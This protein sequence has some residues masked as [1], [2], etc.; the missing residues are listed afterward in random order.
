VHA[1]DDDAELAAAKALVAVEEGDAATTTDSTASEA[2]G[3]RT[4]RTR[5]WRTTA[6]PRKRRPVPGTASGS[7][8]R[9]VAPS[10]RSSRRDADDRSLPITFESITD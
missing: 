6:K 9:S 7:S 8:L 10:G 4:R 1:A 2:S 5:L 3:P